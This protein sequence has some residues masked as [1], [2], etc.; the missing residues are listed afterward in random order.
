MVALHWLIVLGMLVCLLQ[1]QCNVNLFLP[2]CNAQFTLY[3]GASKHT[4]E[5]CKVLLDAG[6]AVDAADA[7]GAT[8]LLVACGSG[9]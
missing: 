3:L 2:F 6:A 9:R 4:V 5:L 1:N 8:S 7:R